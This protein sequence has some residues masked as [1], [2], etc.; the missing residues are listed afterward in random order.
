MYIYIYIY[1]HN[2]HTHLSCAAVTPARW[3]HAFFELGGVIISK[4][5]RASV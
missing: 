2:T 4:G 1:T 3:Q 5:T